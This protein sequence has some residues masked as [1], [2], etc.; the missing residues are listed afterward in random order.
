[1]FL[2]E[3]TNTFT[4]TVFFLNSLANLLEAWLKRTTGPSVTGVGQAE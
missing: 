4:R 2:F 3:L 1:V